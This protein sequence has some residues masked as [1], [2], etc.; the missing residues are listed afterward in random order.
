M[1]PIISLKMPENLRNALKDEDFRVFYAES[2]DE[3]EI[4]LSGVV[5]DEYTD[6]DAA[7]ISRILRSNRGK[8]VTMRVNS[9]GGLAFDGLA[10]YNAIAE[11]DGPTTG[12]IEAVAASAASLAVLGADKVMMQENATYHIHE[13]LAFAFGHVAELQETIGWLESFNEAAAKTYAAQT[14]QPVKAMRSALLGA[15]GDG[16]K[17]TAE[18]ALAQGFIDEIVPLK[19]KAATKANTSE[20]DMRAMARHRIQQHHLTRHR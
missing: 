3:I 2:A 1:K 11:H 18:E 5:G 17:Y 13:G 12:I 7:T 19:K 15:N 8:P 6:S 9:F 10:I 20:R 14:G 4:Y 16:T